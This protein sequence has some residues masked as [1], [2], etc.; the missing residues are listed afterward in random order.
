MVSCTGSCAKRLSRWRAFRATHIFFFIRYEQF[1]ETTAF[2]PGLLYQEFQLSEYG[3]FNTT[4]DP[5]MSFRDRH[6]FLDGIYNSHPSPNLITAKEIGDVARRLGLLMEEVLLWFDDER[7][8]RATLLAN[9]QHRAQ[10]STYQFPPSPESTRA[11]EA[12][13]AA[14]PTHNAPSPATPSQVLDIL[15]PSVAT[16]EPKIPVTPTPKRGRPAKTHANVEI[17]PSSP[18]AKR[19]KISMKYPCPDCGNFV[20]VARWAEHIDRK[21]FPE[22]VWECPKTNQQ[23]GTPCSSNPKYK[24]SYRHDNFATHLKDKHDCPESEV[25][26]LKRTCKFEVLDFFH[27]ICG[28]C[29]KCLKTRGESIE[30]IREHFREISR[31]SS[32]PADF[33]LSLWKEK[34]GSEHKLQLGVHYRRTQASNS[35]IIDKVHDEDENGE[36]GDG[37]S[38]DSG[39]DGSGHQRKNNSHNHDYDQDEN[40]NGG[41]GVESSDNQAQDSLAFQL[42]NSSHDLLTRES[43]EH[44]QSLHTQHASRLYHRSPAMSQLSKTES[45]TKQ[46][47]KSLYND[48]KFNQ[49]PLSQQECIQSHSCQDNVSSEEYREKA[50]G[51]CSYPECGKIFK[52]LKAHM[53]THQHERPEKCPIQTCDYHIKGFARKYDMNR[54]TLTH[55]KDTMICGFCPGSGSMAEKSFNRADVFKRHLTS[56]H[57]VEQTPPN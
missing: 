38:D 30:H 3:I 11:A 31:E 36:S 13:G 2:M 54:H 27:K 51:L 39:G 52:D 45:R 40:G 15:L 26:E 14:F 28:F 34:C 44:V 43:E 46:G 19:R 37:N 16:V 21:H 49:S 1:K 23:T 6:R 20:S 42:N 56:V 50:K 48:S 24:P 12:I 55:Y 57:A 22:N 17:N 53:L 35:E 25:I 8:R 5:P 41:S 7:A 32:P 18:D 10:P 33:G 9:F 4:R 47:S 29:G